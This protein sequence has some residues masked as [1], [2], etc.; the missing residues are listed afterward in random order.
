MGAA[1]QLR[2]NLLWA[3][4]LSDNRFK[5]VTIALKIKVS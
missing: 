4:N 2:F 5:K 1:A 3:E